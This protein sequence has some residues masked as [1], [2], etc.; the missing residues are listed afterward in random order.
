M[1]ILHDKGPAQWESGPNRVL[2]LQPP[3]QSLGVG[4]GCDPGGF[5][6]VAHYGLPAYN[7]VVYRAWMGTGG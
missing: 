5:L 6:V 7:Q 4:D 1:V 3:S 2:Q